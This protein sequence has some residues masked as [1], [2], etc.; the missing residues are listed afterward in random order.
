M[1]LNANRSDKYAWVIRVFCIV[2]GGIVAWAGFYGFFHGHFWYSHYN[3]R[4]GQPVTGDSLGFGFLGLIILV[5]GLIRPI[6]PR[7]KSR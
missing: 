5:I 7:E 2:F 4:I 3:A 1:T 6:K